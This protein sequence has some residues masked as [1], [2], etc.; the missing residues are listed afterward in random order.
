VPRDRDVRQ[1]DDRSD[2]YEGGWRGNLHRRIADRSADIAIACAPKPKHI[3][4]IGCGTGYLQRQLAER[5][6]DTDDLVGIDPAPGMIE[7]AIHAN[8]GSRVRFGTGV[9]EHLSYPDEVFD[10]IIMTTSFDKSPKT[11]HC[12]IRRNRS[13][14]STTGQCSDR[15]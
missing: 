3:L 8:D 9:A 14:N 1:Y 11:D 2:G 10:L 13:S 4:D 15:A 7:A 12:A 5:C 6:P